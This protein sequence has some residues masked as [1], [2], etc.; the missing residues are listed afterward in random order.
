LDIAQRSCSEKYPMSANSPVTNM[1]SG[2][3]DRKW[4]SARQS[5]VM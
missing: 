5:H 4:E 1:D 3:S 2:I